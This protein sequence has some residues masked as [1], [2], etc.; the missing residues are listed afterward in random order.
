RLRK[1]RL[2]AHRTGKG[3]RER[4]RELARRLR[5][6]LEGERVEAPRD[7]APHGGFR[8]SSWH[9]PP[10]VTLHS[11]TIKLALGTALRHTDPL[12]SPAFGRRTLEGSS[13][14]VR[15]R[16]LRDPSRPGAR[17]PR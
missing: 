8:G 12:R 13:Q 1:A 10:I 15:S 6:G 11:A 5:V 4:P 17:L 16:P 3:G 9:E 14:E 7:R 2:R